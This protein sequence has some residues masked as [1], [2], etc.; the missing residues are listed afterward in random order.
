MFEV[1]GL[2]ED[3]SKQALNLAA[4][5]LSVKTKIITRHDVAGE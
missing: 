3:V 5:K 1:G 4:Y 2:P